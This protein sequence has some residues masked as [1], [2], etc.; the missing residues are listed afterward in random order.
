[1]AL[2]SQ[3]TT[4]PSCRAG[5]RPFGLSA[6]YDGSR[7]PPKAP[8]TSVCSC[9]TAVSPT[10]HITFCTLDEFLRPQIFSIALPARVGESGEGE[11]RNAASAF[12]L[13]RFLRQH[14]RN[15]V[16]DRVGELGRAGD[17]LLLLGVIFQ[18]AL[19]QR[20]DQDFQE[21]RID[22]AERSVG[23]G[24]AHDFSLSRYCNGV[25]SVDPVLASSISV[26]ATSTS[27]RVLRSCASKSACFSADP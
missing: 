6:K 13:A 20:A 2:D 19:G 3:S 7:L 10:A 15:A 26:S 5:T 27:A 22:A 16:A 1:M 21:L 17:Q 14:D 4:S 25:S 9:M 18:R 11:G 8:P 24:G 23:D 12:Q